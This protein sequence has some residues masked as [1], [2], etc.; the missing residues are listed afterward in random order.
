[1]S[2]LNQ[3]ADLTLSGEEIQVGTM[4]EIG[5]TASVWIKT[6]ENSEPIYMSVVEAG[7]LTAALLAATEEAERT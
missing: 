7:L 1:M 5:E 3:I 2:E 6:R 4:K